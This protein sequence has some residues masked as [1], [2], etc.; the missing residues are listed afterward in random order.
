MPDSETQH[1][2]KPR[3]PRLQKRDLIVKRHKVGKTVSSIDGLQ[4]IPPRVLN[5]ISLM[6]DHGMGWIDAANAADISA[7]TLKRYL[8]QPHVLAEFNQQMQVLYES[9]RPRNVAVAAEIR[10]NTELPAG[11]RVAALKHLNALATPEPSKVGSINFNGGVVISPGYIVNVAAHSDK[12]RLILQQSGSSKN[13]IDHQADELTVHGE[14]APST[15]AKGSS[16]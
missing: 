12:A 1:A 2:P 10:D 9:H 15:A 11:A 3:L 5:A 16:R 6:V 13:I 7:A 8:R 4:R 14:S